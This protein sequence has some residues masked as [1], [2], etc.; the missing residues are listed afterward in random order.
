LFFDTDKGKT[1][2]MISILDLG[3]IIV[4]NR[5]SLE[6]NLLSYGILLESPYETFVIGLAI[7][8]TCLAIHTVSSNDTSLG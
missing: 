5:I 3:H 8:F 1:S 2:E 6:K 4:P 7:R